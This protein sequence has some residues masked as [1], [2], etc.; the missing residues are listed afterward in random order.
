[1][2]NVL[3]SLWC[4]NDIHSIEIVFEIL[5][6]DLFWPEDIDPFPWVPFPSTAVL[7]NSSKLHFPLILMIIR[8]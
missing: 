7:G 3:T 8:K 5:D 6:F 2:Y 1:M 4:Q